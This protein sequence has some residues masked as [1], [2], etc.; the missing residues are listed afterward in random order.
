[1]KRIFLALALMSLLLC[2]CGK[3][4]A[5]EK[6]EAPTEAAVE[7]V[8]EGTTPPDGN[9]GDVT[10]KGSYT[11]GISTSAVVATAGEGKLTAGE[12]Q[13]WYWAQVGQYRQAGYEISPD[14]DRPLDTQACEIDDS[15][16]SWQQYFLREALNSWHAAQ[17]LVHHSQT[18]PLETE[19]AYQPVPANYEEYMDGMPATKVLYGYNEYYSPNSMHQQFLDTL[20][21]TMEALA[22]VHGYAGAAD[23]AMKAFA[24]G[25]AE[26]NAAA[27]LYNQ[28]Y[29]YFTQLTYGVDN[30]EEA[31]G[32]YYEENK[33]DYTAEGSYVNIRHILLNEEAEAEELLK[34]WEK[35]K[36][37]EAI[38][39][40]LA[41]KQS[42]D[43]GSAINGGAYRRVRQGQLVKPL[44]AWCFAPERQPGDTTV[45]TTEAG[46]HVLY[47]SGWESIARVEAEADFLAEQEMAILA[48]ITELCPMEVNYSAITLGAADGTVSTADL[49]YPDV[50]HERYPELPLYL[51][52]DYG[53]QMYGGWLLRTNGCGITS[54]AMVASYF[55]DTEYTPPEMCERYGKYSFRN[56]T[57]G[58]IYQKEGPVLGFYVK[59]K[60]YDP[61]AAKAALE[62]G[63]IVIS[64]QH[65]GYW[66]RGG[67]YIVLE[68][69]DEDGMV[70]VRD[71][72]LYNYR[73]I[74]AHAED[75]HTWGSITSAGSGYWIFEYKAAAIPGCSRCGTPETIE[76]DPLAEE[77]LC[78]KC[79]PALMRRNVYLAARD[80]K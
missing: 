79:T 20:P 26:L 24:A 47:F 65:N 13:V 71:S 10:C 53:N 43:T 34:T 15:V 7:T 78:E 61:K 76:G 8:P 50:A 32:A 31:V 35:N 6:T 22:E 46:V 70:Q 30:S 57:D 54:M 45:I 23:L 29:M 67:H 25:E 4:G 1:M 51:Q 80:V 48:E 68:S 11:G 37:T 63:R 39:A 21:D 33:S 66:T 44:D 17:A 69:I 16:A 38:F 74:G 3:L 42:L 41:N 73:R 12:L 59:E 2:G 40:D 58:Q 36:S 14:F 9:P 52:Q 19:E 60:T 75:R 62:E 55:T 49:L 72:N 56:G 5:D 77:Y 64:I 28:G 27:R 18:V